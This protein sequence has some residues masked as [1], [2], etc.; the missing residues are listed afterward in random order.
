MLKEE[1][2]ALHFGWEE[3]SLVFASAWK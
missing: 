1:V 2:G 3:K